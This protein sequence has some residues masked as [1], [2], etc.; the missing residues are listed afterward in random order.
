MPIRPS[1]LPWW[2]WLLCAV[3]AG[4][5]SVVCYMSHEEGDGGWMA[6][7]VSIVGAVATLLLFVIGLVRFVKWA[8]L[9]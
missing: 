7:V 3:G 5:V 6:F 1:D 4:I 2:G 8:W 9:G